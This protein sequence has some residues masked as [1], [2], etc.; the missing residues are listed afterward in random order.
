MMEA[1]VGIEAKIVLVLLSLLGLAV[2]RF[3]KIRTLSRCKHKFSTIID[4]DIFAP[5]HRSSVCSRG[6]GNP[7]G[8]TDG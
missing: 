4:W 7:D 8:C 2:R 1:R 5:A 3:N 6:S